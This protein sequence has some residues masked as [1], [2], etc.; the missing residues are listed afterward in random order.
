MRS[1]PL[2]KNK[3]LS[4]CCRKCPTES[5]KLH[6][7]PACTGGLQTRHACILCTLHTTP[8]IRT[9]HYSTFRAP[10]QLPIIWALAGDKRFFS[11]CCSLRPSCEI[12]GLLL[13]CCGYVAHVT[14]GCRAT[15]QRIGAMTFHNGTWPTTTAKKKHS[16]DDCCEHMPCYVVINVPGVLPMPM[17]AIAQCVKFVFSFLVFSSVQKQSVRASMLC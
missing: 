1:W 16:I 13:C 11:G 7:K 2:L 5:K 8:Q 9:D 14:S 3:L 12:R 17:A 10:R 6:T 15:V 4:A